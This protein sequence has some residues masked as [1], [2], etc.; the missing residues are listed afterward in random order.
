MK[1]F[2]AAVTA[3]EQYVAQTGGQSSA[4]MS[5]GLR[6]ILTV[7]IAAYLRESVVQ[8][9]QS[10]SDEYFFDPDPA[11][12]PAVVEESVQPLPFTLTYELTIAPRDS[13]SLRQYRKVA[14]TYLY[15]E[16]DGWWSAY[17]GD[18][19]LF[20]MPNPATFTEALINQIK[21]SHSQLGEILSVEQV[22]EDRYAD[23]E[24]VN[25]DPYS[26]AISEME[27]EIAQ[28]LAQ[29][30]LELFDI[31]DLDFQKP[32]YPDID[33]LDLVHVI[34]ELEDQYDIAISDSDIFI[35]DD[36]FSVTWFELVR[37]VDKLIK[38]R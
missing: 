20:T 7:A 32:M 31:K 37:I 17:A 30:A 11:E 21:Q 5:S 19:Y 25:E 29:V 24:Q 22:N 26:S 16:Q 14:I 15:R 13:W 10:Q 4:A 36:Q 35:E 8:V 1:A 28:F 12:V 9:A 6:K 34:L 18:G 2:D 33:T 23:T 27:I 38:D 3:A